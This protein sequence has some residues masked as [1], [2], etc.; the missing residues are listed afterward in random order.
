MTHNHVLGRA[1]YPQAIAVIGVSRAEGNHPPGYTGLSFLR[2]L[3]K[4]GFEG[5]IYPIKPKA[6]VIESVKEGNQ[7]QGGINE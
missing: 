5:R 3:Q 4:A 7:S 1:S 2:L 6:A